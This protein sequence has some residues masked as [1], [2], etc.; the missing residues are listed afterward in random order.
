MKVNTEEL[1]LFM[2]IGC[3]R[4]EHEVVQG[5]ALQ[6]GVSCWPLLCQVVKSPSRLCLPGVNKPLGAPRTCNNCETSRKSPPQNPRARHIYLQSVFT[7]AAAC[8]ELG[9][10]IP[11]PHAPPGKEFTSLCSPICAL[12]T[13]TRFPLFDFCS[14]LAS[15]SPPLNSSSL[16]CFS[17]LLHHGSRLWSWT[18]TS[19]S[20]KSQ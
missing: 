2:E 15:K 12:T 7:V 18:R 1:H 20:L 10:A 3:N 19:M 14:Q 5:L 13:H 8:A 17:F 16:H 4:V 11:F 9:W 6:Q